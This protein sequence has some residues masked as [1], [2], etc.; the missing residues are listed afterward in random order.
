MEC[1][2]QIP[3]QAHGRDYEIRVLHED[4]MIN[5]AA[6]L[7]HRPANGFRYRLM[8]PKTIG[9]DEVLKQENYL[10]L[11]EYAKDDIAQN[12]WQNLVQTKEDV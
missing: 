6:F 8:V 10:H 2:K 3:F 4:Q 5:I 1:Y 12:R 9:V 7:D 11:V